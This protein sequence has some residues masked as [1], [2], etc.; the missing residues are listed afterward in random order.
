MQISLSHEFD[1]SHDALELAL[2]SPDLAAR[3]ATHFQH[4][5]AVSLKSHA[6][7]AGR[8]ERVQVFQPNITVPPFARRVLTRE[9]CAWDER[10]TY[11]LRRHRAEWTLEPHV[12]PEWRRLFRATGSYELVPLGEDR[13]RRI[14]EGVMLLNVP[15]IKAAA[16]RLLVAELRRAFDAEARALRELAELV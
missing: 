2:L 15:V 14:V 12:K 11:D 4:M 8:L 10:F 9:M 5:E 16:E 6:V 3:I 1:I 13:T 7:T